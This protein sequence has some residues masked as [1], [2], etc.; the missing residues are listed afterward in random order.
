MGPEVATPFPSLPSNL[1]APN[2]ITIE[3]ET[4][5]LFILLTDDLD[6]EDGFFVCLFV[7]LTLQNT[8]GT[9]KSILLS[10][11][12]VGSLRPI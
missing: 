3:K 10:L 7:P 12:E 9:N 1:P 6:K 5:L 2:Q 8:R 11:S 4:I